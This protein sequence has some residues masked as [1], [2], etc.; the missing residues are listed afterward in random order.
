MMNDPIK[1]GQLPPGSQLHPEALELFE[2]SMRERR[3][4]YRT[5]QLQSIREAL[6]E[7]RRGGDVMVIEQLLAE[8]QLAAKVLR[9]I[10]W[11]LSKME[12]DGVKDWMALRVRQALAVIE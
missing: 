10:E 3:K 2:S 11:I 7:A 4:E 6:Y 5:G 12:P 8:K 1:R 9:E